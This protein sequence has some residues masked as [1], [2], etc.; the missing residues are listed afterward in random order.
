MACSLLFPRDIAEVMNMA[1]RT[2]TSRTVERILGATRPDLAWRYWLATVVLLGIGLSGW[3]IGLYL[4]IALCSVQVIHFAVRG[5][6]LTTLPVQLRV[7]D[8]GMLLA[9]LWA[10]WEFI[11]WIQ[12]GGTSARVL[13]GY[14][15][16]ARNLSLLSW[17]RREPVSWS[18][19]HR[20][21]FSTHVEECHGGR[22]ACAVSG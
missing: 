15:L 21:F 22:S 19:L 20:T 17:N 2:F 4:A 12:L 10:P 6:S 1:A 13:A 14:C 16:L 5:S 8:L 7:A 11:H 3:S 18:L 9:G